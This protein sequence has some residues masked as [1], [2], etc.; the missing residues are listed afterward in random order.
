M[1]IVLKHRGKEI[2]LENDIKNFIIH[3]GYKTTI[4]KKTGQET[5]EKIEPAYYSNFEMFLNG[6]LKRAMHLSEAKTIQDLFNEVIEVK[7]LI[8][9]KVRTK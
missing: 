7:R 5:R 8:F 2:W 1:E 6:I 9:E 4:N 3:G